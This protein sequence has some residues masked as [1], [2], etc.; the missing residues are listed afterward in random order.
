MSESLNESVDD[1]PGW[2]LFGE[3]KITQMATCLLCRSKFANALQL[4]AHVRVCTAQNENHGH[5]GNIDDNNTNVI[6]QP[7]SLHDLARRP[8]GAWG[9]VSQEVQQVQQ[10]NIGCHHVY[11]RD[12]REV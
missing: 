1:T 5:E 7:A 12:Y 6:L 9:R 3:R 4:G 8:A 2:K 10:L 11:A